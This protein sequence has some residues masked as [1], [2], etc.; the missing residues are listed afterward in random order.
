MT[1]DLGSQPVVQ[2][3]PG[4]FTS[5]NYGLKG[6]IIANLSPFVLQVFTGLNVKRLY[7]NTLDWF[8][9]S[10]G[11]NG[12]ITWKPQTVVSNP[13]SYTAS[14]I[15]FTAVGILENIDTSVYPMAL[16]LPAVN[17]TASGDPI[18][19]AT[20]GFGSTL[21][22][23]QILNIFDPINSGATCTFHSARVFT[24]D[25]TLGDNALLLMQS[26]PDPN[27]T[28]PVPI[29]NNSGQPGI[30]SVCHA[31]AADTASL[32]PFNIPS[33]EVEVFNTT[34][35][36]TLEF[37]SFPDNK[38]L[39]PGNNLAIAMVDGGATKVTRLTTKWTEKINL[40]IIMIAPP[41]PA[42][43]GGLFM[44]NLTG[45]Y[46][47]LDYGTISGVA[48]DDVAVRKA[49]NAAVSNGGGWVLMHPLKHVFS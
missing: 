32:A 37:L 49:Y 10:K 16:T 47:P 48:N 21:Q 43:P 19:S 35:N 22:F 42:K 41:P 25:T 11:F 28:I 7:P 29:Q 39:L 38:I 27:Y 46:S 45:I 1:M 12:T 24:S 31:S 6:L 40:P 9:I 8:A 14:T 3:V 17:P 15:S 36:Q 20:I 23:Q 34:Q 30:N 13:S 4:Y 18:F 33:S 26:G 44:P 5:P 2:N